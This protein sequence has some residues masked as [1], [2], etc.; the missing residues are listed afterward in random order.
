MNWHSPQP[1]YEFTMLALFG[2]ALASQMTALSFWGARGLRLSTM[3]RLGVVLQVAGAIL[4]YYGRNWHQPWTEVGAPP[5]FFGI[6]LLIQPPDDWW[7]RR[8][9]F[10]EKIN[11]RV[12]QVLARG[13]PAKRPAEAQT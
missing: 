1:S 7:K 3:Q 5:Y 11:W 8:R 10:L 6:Y 2:V 12:R 4:I 9:R 13:M